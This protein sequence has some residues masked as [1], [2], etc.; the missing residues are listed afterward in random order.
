M[1]TTTL[2]TPYPVR[3]PSPAVRYLC[4]S[5]WTCHSAGRHTWRNRC[6][7][8]L[9][10]G[11]PLS[12][13]PRPIRESLDL[14]VAPVPGW[15]GQVLT[16]LGVPC[17]VGRVATWLPVQENPGQLREFSLLALCPQHDLDDAPPYLQL[18]TQFLLEVRAQVFLD[19][20]APSAG[21]KLVIP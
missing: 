17:R 6:D 21:G 20:T 10:T 1:A 13:I 12:L 9:A 2:L 8:L 5:W 19:G 16:W 7:A 11:Q 18:G 15:R 4:Q 3:L 14:V